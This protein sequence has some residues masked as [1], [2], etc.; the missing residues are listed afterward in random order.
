MCINGAMDMSFVWFG[1]YLSLAAFCE[2]LHIPFLQFD[3]F[4]EKLS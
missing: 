4:L 2:L 1:F 3:F